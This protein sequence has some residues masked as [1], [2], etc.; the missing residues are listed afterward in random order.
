MY[1][2]VHVDPDTDI[3]ERI[4]NS[5][6]SILAII[7]WGSSGEYG[8]PVRLTRKFPLALRLGTY[9]CH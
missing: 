7:Y 2:L 5:D 8:L 9:M 6:I 3:D 4:S 1:I